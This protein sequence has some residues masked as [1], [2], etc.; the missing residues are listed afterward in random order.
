MRRALYALPLL[1]LAGLLLACVPPQGTPFGAGTINPWFPLDVGHHWTYTGID[2]GRYTVDQVDVTAATKT[3][4]T[5][6]NTIQANVVTD[7]VYKVCAGTQPSPCYYLA[8]TTRD[9]YATANDGTVYYLG[10]E[11]AELNRNG[12]VT[13]TAGSWQAGI[14]GASGGIFM[15]N[16][17]QPGQ[18]YQQE[19]AAD[20][21]DFFRI[22]AIIFDTMGVTEWSALEPGV[23]EH[24]QYH[25]GVGLTIDG[26]LTLQP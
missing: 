16:N 23:T 6:G 7:Q 24:K 5:N 15:P 17:P 22:D 13:S 12:Q 25:R 10:E 26:G 14:N 18:Q 9:F 4:V 1:P 8:E 3:I 2:E 19:H 20:A 21:Q 11:T